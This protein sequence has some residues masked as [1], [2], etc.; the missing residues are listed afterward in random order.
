MNRHNYKQLM[1]QFDMDKKYT[2][3][4]QVFANTF[5]FNFLVVNFVSIKWNTCTCTLL[6]QFTGTSAIIREKNL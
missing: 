4:Y 6:C 3:S 2:L 5:L 1:K